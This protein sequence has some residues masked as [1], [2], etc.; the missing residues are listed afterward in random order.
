MVQNYVI[1]SPLEMFRQKEDCHA[2]NLK[3]KQN[4]V[5]QIQCHFISVMEPKIVKKK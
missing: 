4:A 1:S 3:V 5:K 2:A